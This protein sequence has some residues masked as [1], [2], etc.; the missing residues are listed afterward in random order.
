MARVLDTE[1]VKRVYFHPIQY[2]DLA[3]ENRTETNRIENFLD[4]TDYA[5]IKWFHGRSFVVPSWMVRQV[6]VHEYAAAG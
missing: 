3:Y 2:I 1:S 5:G 6:L 4:F